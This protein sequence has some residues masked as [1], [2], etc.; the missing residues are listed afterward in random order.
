MTT[1]RTHAPPGWPDVIPRLSVESPQEAVEFIK[2]VFG[3]TGEYSAG[4]PTELCIGVSVIMVGGILERAPTNTFLYVYVADTD[5]AYRKALEL[6]AK[7]IE[8]PA[9]MSY[10]DRRSMIEDKWGN[11]WQIATHRKFSDDE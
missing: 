11:R 8:E 4:R 6:G 2:A 10:G 5:E 9:E 3:A 7:S 1:D